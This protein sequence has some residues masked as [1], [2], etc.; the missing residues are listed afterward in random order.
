MIA[1]SGGG[2]V[3]RDREPRDR[4]GVTRTTTTFF[5]LQPRGSYHQ[6]LGFSFSFLNRGDMPSSKRKTGIRAT[7]SRAAGVR[8]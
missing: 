5:V 7:A 8:W 3:A 6:C 1:G 4:P 2:L